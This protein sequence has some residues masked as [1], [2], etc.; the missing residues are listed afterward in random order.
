[1]KDHF[2]V[3]FMLSD[4]WWNMLTEK[5]L[6]GKKKKIESYFYIPYKVLDKHF[7]AH[8]DTMLQSNDIEMFGKVWGLEY[9]Y[10]FLREYTLIDKEDFTRMN[11]NISSIKYLFMR[12]TDENL[13]KMSY[14]FNWPQLYV[15]DPYDK[16]VFQSTSILRTLMKHSF[17]EAVRSKMGVE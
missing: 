9:V 8:Y 11:E 14:I 2:D 12:I 10:H 4:R 7:A 16:E 1:M 6:F 13:W 5:G 3:P 17:C 15:P